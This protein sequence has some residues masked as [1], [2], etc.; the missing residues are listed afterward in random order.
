MNGITFCEK[1]DE[2]LFKPCHLSKLGRIAVE[3]H[4]A[5]VHLAFIG[6]IRNDITEHNITV[7][8][9]HEDASPFLRVRQEVNSE[10]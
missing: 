1:F 8:L 7:T 3:H 2:V 4:D 9:C 6:I 5:D 10:V